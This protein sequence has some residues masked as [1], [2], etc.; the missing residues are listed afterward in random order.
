MD[1][2]CLVLNFGQKQSPAEGGCEKETLS[3]SGVAKSW[4]CSIHGHSGD[5]QFDHRCTYVM[6]TIYTMTGPA[7]SW[8]GSSSF[9]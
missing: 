7:S 8:L 6:E 3:I 4:V 2:L 5:R 9:E 1:V